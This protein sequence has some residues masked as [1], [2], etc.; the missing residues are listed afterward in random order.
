MSVVKEF[1]LI[2]N[3]YQLEQGALRR[4]QLFF[5]GFD[6]MSG[7]EEPGQKIAPRFKQMADDIGSTIETWKGALSNTG[8]DDEV[9]EFLDTHDLTVF[10]AEK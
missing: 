8:F 5:E 10:W 7:V 4:I 9:R 6:A 1:A 3:L 2:I